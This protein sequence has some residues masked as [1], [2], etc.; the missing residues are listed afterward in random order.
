MDGIIVI[1]TP[2]N[3]PNLTESGCDLML[4]GREYVD[5][6]SPWVSAQWQA[7]TP[8]YIILELSAL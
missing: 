6:T 2:T 5:Q 3:L 7:V 1:T 8:C 4:K